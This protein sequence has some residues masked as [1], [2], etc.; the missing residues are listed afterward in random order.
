MSLKIFEATLISDVD[1]NTSPVVLTA[2]QMKIAKKKKKKR[3]RQNK[4]TKSWLLQPYKDYLKHLSDEGW[5]DPNPPPTNNT[6]HVE[7]NPTSSSKN[8]V[9]KPSPFFFIYVFIR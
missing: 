2:K 9:K 5:Y 4:N 8:K 6:T 1:S 7:S 3:Q